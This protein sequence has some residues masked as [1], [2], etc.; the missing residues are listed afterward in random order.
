M[1]ARYSGTSIVVSS[2]ANGAFKI[3]NR[4]PSLTFVDPTM[5]DGAYTRAEYLG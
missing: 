2:I 5:G 1:G 3:G 4:D